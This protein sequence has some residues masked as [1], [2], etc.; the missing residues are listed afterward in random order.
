MWHVIPSPF[1]RLRHNIRFCVRMR[2][3]FVL[4]IRAYEPS[5]PSGVCQVVLFMPRTF[6][7]TTRESCRFTFPPMNFSR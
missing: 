7:I 6:A 5:F 3:R 2:K 1:D 4:L